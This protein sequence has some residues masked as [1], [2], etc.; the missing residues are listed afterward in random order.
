[1]TMTRRAGVYD[2]WLI[3]VHCRGRNTFMS[4]SASITPPGDKCKTAATATDTG[5]YIHIVQKVTLLLL[6]IAVTNLS[7]LN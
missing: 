7:I 2:L 4:D 3:N 5:V 1:M 6:T